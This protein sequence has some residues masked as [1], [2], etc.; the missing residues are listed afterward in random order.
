[1]EKNLVYIP[2]H[3][4]DPPRFLFWSIDEAGVLILPIFFGLF[5][6]FLCTGLLFGSALLVLFRKLKQ[7]RGTTF[8]L[9]ACYW[10][11]PYCESIWRATPPSHIRE[12]FG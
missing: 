8:F 6:G 9:S 1:M 10:Y 3:L 2:K 11:L 12:Y 5:F 4:D 7:G